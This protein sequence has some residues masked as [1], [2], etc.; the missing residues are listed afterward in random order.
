MRTR[1][2]F[3]VS[4]EMKDGK[5]SH[6]EITSLAGEKCLVNYDNLCHLK[7]SAPVKT[8]DDHTAEIILQKGETAVFTL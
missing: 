7:C 3:L 2:A 4:A 6:V 1:G 5:I 8:Q